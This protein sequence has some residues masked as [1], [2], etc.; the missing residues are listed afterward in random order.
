[1][2]H[3]LF[4]NVNV[5]FCCRGRQPLVDMLSACGT[6]DCIIVTTDLILN[7]EV[8]LE[9]VLPLLNTISF[10][11]HPTSSMISHLSVRF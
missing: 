2:L 7:K 4:Y 8:D 10:T 5:G 11:S 9:H 1:L 6:E 3:L